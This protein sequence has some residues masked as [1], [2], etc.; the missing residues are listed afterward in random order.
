MGTAKNSNTDAT[1]YKIGALVKT[2]SYAENVQVVERKEDQN[3]VVMSCATMNDGTHN[4]MY[5]YVS[6]DGFYDN[7]YSLSTQRV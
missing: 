2:K 1:S 3:A 6:E 4:T 5:E 7:P